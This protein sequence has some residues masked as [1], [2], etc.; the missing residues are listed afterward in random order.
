LK[1]GNRI[2]TW[3]SYVSFIWISW[4]PSWSLLYGS[5]IYNY[6]LFEI[7]FHFAGHRS[8]TQEFSAGPSEFLTDLHFL[9]KIVLKPSFG[10]FWMVTGL[11]IFRPL[12]VLMKL[13][14]ESALL[15]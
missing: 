6:R 5:W 8:S 2:A 10:L 4:R 7:C 9:C 11:P 12:P 3:L 15:D 14:T 1:T 13:N